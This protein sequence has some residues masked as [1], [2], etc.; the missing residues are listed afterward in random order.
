MYKKNL[1]V[2]L[3][4]AFITL[5]SISSGN[6]QMESSILFVA[7][8]RVIINSDQKIEVINVANKSN[9]IRRYD[10]M[11][12][13]QVMDEN[14]TTQRQDN[15][16][17]SARRMLR[18]VPKRVTL[19]PGER[20]VVRV[21]A[22]RPKGLAD[23]DYHA[24]LLFR[25]I[26]LNALDKRQLQKDDAAKANKAKTTFEIKTLY[27]IAVPVVIQSGTI[28]S[29]VEF[30][31]ASFIP[32]TDTASAHISAVFNRLGNSEGAAMFD[33]VFLRPGAEPVNIV[34]SQWIRLYREV[35]SITKNMSLTKEARALD[36]SQGK[37]ILTLTTKSTDPKVEDTVVEKILQF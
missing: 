24:H 2:I 20:Q 29:G 32:T 17:F 33:A 22:R 18:F 15:F 5:F 13:D 1:L 10:L 14:G 9:E 34:K 16:E 31:D 4:L 35:N 25:E 3:T 30:A 8:H 12:I 7:P 28:T 11:V 26:P 21:M 27:G 6:T 37:V 19:K 23:G 36:L